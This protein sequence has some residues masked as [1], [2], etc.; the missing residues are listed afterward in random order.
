M[1][2][3]MKRRPDEPEENDIGNYTEQ[4]H[5][6]FQTRPHRTYPEYQKARKVFDKFKEPMK[7]R[8]DLDA[9][10]QDVDTYGDKKHKSRQK[11]RLL[12]YAEDIRDRASVGDDGIQHSD[13]T[14]LKP[15]EVNDLVET[16]TRGKLSATGDQQRK[17]R[18]RIE[19]KTKTLSE[20]HIEVTTS[21]SIA[22]VIV[23]ERFPGYTGK[24]L[25]SRIRTVQGG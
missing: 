2:Y 18:S 5:L 17:T 3:D 25:K 6:R 20:G 23:S 22:D 11:R 16:I 15:R 8:G 14:R 19:K 7:I 21:V 12:L 9:Y 13:G 1:D 4:L 24:A 10:L